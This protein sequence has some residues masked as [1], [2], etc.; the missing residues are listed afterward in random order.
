MECSIDTSIS[1]KE[2]PKIIRQQREAVDEKIRELS[3]SHV[4][5]PGLEYFVKKEASRLA[6]ATGGADS[7]VKVHRNA[8]ERERGVKIEDI[9]GV[10][11]AQWLGVEATPAK[12]RLVGTE[13]APSE[14]ELYNMCSALFKGIRSHESSWPFQEPVDPNEVPDYYEIVKEP[15]GKLFVYQLGLNSQE[16]I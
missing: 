11:E 10:K 3:N 13:G 16:V 5:Y 8:L 7:E 4:V 15:I 6:A 2:F 9:P 1:Y 14:T 12:L